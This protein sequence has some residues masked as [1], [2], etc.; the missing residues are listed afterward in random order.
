MHRTTP[1]VTRLGERDRAEIESHFIALGRED[2]R[3]RFGN[4]IADEGIAAYVARIDF[5]QDGVFGARDEALGLVGVVHAGVS[6]AEAELGLSVLP[7]ARA[8]GI[9]G[10]LFVRA[11]SHLRNRGVR[12]VLV[13]CLSENAA[14]LHLA[15]KH[16][17]RLVHQ[18]TESRARLA[19]EAPTPA[20]RIDEWLFDQEA[21]M[22]VAI[23]QG[24]RFFAPWTAAA[25][26]ARPR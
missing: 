16:G 13:H 10:S 24:M 4:A 22:V 2:R 18:G 11:M 5:V 12:E 23:R 20:S 19:I 26:P 8:E 9:G 21:A 14:M 1:V 25:S 3:L 6:G 17:M 7:A 15:R